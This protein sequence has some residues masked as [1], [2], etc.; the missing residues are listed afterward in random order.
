MQI[1][2]RIPNALHIASFPQRIRIE[3]TLV[4]GTL[5]ELFASAGRDLSAAGYMI[6]D[7]IWDP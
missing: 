3:V 1:T 7:M 5:G 2:L 4:N 6:L